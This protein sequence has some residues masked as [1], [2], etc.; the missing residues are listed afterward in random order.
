MCDPSLPLRDVL[1]QLPARASPRRLQTHAPGVEGINILCGMARIVDALNPVRNPPQHGA[2]W[3]GIAIRAGSIGSGECCEEPAVLRQHKVALRRPATF[4][5]LQSVVLSLARI[6]S[7]PGCCGTGLGF[8]PSQ[9][10]F[11]LSCQLFAYANN[12]GK[13]FFIKF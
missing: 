5:I 6:P 9:L 4:S 7:R 11:D 13:V 10:D 1:A 8:H 12:F 2:P 3:R